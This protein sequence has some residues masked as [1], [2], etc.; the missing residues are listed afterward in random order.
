MSANFIDT[1]PVTLGASGANEVVV[2]DSLES[3]VAGVGE[4]LGAV[5]QALP[6]GR[7]AGQGWRFFMSLYSVVQQDLISK[8]CSSAEMILV[9]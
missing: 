3:G 5:E 2:A 4:G 7:S 9:Y 6:R 8:F 1:D